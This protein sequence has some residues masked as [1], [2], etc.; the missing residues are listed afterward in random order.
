VKSTLWKWIALAL[1]VSIIGAGAALAEVGH[2][3]HWGS[4]N[5]FGGRNLHFM[6]RYLNLTEDQQAQIKQIMQKEKP[7]FQPLMQQI[8]Q[9]RSQER[10][11][12]EAE[13]FDENQAR[14]LANQQAQTMAE[15][16]V[17][18]LR[19]E[20]EMYKVLTPE[21]K[22]KLNEFLDRRQHRFSHHQNNQQM[23]DQQGT[24]PQPKNQ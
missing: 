17:Q 1:A 22:T 13:S 18:K 15:L 23:P 8:K 4:A 14:T 2:R 16:T 3:G 10:Q 11:I 12:V 9:A 21:Q 24:N 19:A 7:A 5:A 6:A 20:S